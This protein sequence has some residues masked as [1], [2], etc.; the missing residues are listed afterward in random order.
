M[1]V[2]FVCTGNVCRSPIAE[3]LMRKKFE[4]YDLDGIVDS[5]GFSPTTI[6]DAPDYRAVE[7]A[8]GFNVELTGNSRIFLKNDLHA[9]WT[10]NTFHNIYYRALFC[11]NISKAFLLDS[12]SVNRAAK[13]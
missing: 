4:K 12:N 13:T 3:A 2:L 7:A 8:K 11:E 10:H 5:A 6:N 1:N 9:F